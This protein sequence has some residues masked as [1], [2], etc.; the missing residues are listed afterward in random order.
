MSA[1]ILLVE[2]SGGEHVRKHIGA[3]YNVPWL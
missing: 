1:K 2:H 3:Y